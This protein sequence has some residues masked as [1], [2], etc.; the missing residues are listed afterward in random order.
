M[1]GYA[2]KLKQLVEKSK[3]PRATRRS[4]PRCRLASTSSNNAMAPEV[5][6][7][8][9]HESLRTGLS[10]MASANTTARAFAR[11]PARLSE[12][13]LIRH[14]IEH[15][16]RIRLFRPLGSRATRLLSDAAPDVAAAWGGYARSEAVHDRYFLRDLQA[17]GLDRHAVA[18]TLPFPSTV[19]LVRFV[20]AA[21][22]LYGPL[23]VILYSFWAEENS[24]V[25]SA[26]ILDRTRT[27]FGPQRC[28]GHRLIG[29]ST[30]TSIDRAE[31]GP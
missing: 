18:A 23:P 15:V 5:I 19:G 30:R 3:V 6:R 16:F 8:I 1:L 21:M 27:V 26:R 2:I 29:C 10:R 28:A 25:G 31:R 20:D 11:D 14:L 17:I 4:L 22:R 13:V 7:C 12:Y 24:E 9:L